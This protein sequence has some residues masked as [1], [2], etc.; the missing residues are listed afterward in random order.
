M[1]NSGKIPIIYAHSVGIMWVVAFPFK[2]NGFA[3]VGIDIRVLSACD[4]EAYITN[5][6]IVVPVAFLLRY[7]GFLLAYTS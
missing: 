5:E 6:S 1:T 3:G 7:F 4:L 2:M